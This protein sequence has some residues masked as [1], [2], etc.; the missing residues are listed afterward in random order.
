MLVSVVFFLQPEESV[1]EKEV[2]CKKRLPHHLPWNGT[3][4][5][6]RSPHLPCMWNWGYAPCSGVLHGST[7][8]GFLGGYCLFSINKKRTESSGR[9]TILFFIYF[10]VIL[11]FL[12]VEPKSI[13]R[14]SKQKKKK[15]RRRSMRKRMTEF[16]V[17]RSTLHENVSKSREL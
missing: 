17:G 15:K 9:S 12:P 1:A 11:K 5:S 4:T 16:R 2:F 10:F 8:S 14:Q 13:S 3:W 6:T 7:P